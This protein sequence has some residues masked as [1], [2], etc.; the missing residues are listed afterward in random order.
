MERRGRTLT[1]ACDL[2]FGDHYSC[3]W[4]FIC[5]FTTSLRGFLALRSSR[6]IL[7]RPLSLLTV[8]EIRFFTSRSQS[9]FEVS[10]V[11]NKS[12][13]S[14]IIWKTKKKIY[15]PRD[16]YVTFTPICLLSLAAS[17][18]RDPTTNE[19]QTNVSLDPTWKDWVRERGESNRK[20][21]GRRWAG[22]EKDDCLKWTIVRSEVRRSGSRWSTFAT[23]CTYGGWSNNLESRQVLQV[24]QNYTWF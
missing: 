10:V 17:P 11:S 1:S 7:S 16:S 14:I 6:N 2:T 15:K 13:C 5:T 9:S 18:P 21:G 19:Q 24:S 8:T 4:P 23:N 20:G 22:G 12:W 3:Q